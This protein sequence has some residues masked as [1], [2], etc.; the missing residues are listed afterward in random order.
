MI[1]IG[2]IVAVAMHRPKQVLN[3]PVRMAMVC[4]HLDVIGNRR[5][6]LWR[7]V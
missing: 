1:V 7:M 4:N 6:D 2:H 3:E 5:C